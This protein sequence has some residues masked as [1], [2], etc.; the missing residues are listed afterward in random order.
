MSWRQ[1]AKWAFFRLRDA[2]IFAVLRFEPKFGAEVRDLLKGPF[3]NV[4][5]YSYDTATDGQRFLML[6]PEQ[7]ETPITKLHV[8]VNWT[9]AAKRRLYAG[10]ATTRV[11][12]R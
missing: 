1:L 2:W 5:G 6:M 7:P 10:A 9:E 12:R 11:S 3:L 8:I 4:P